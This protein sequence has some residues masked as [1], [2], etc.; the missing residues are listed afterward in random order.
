MNG[1][2]YGEFHSYN[3]WGLLL[4]SHSISAPVPRRRK[5][6]ILGRHGDL[7][8]S[9]TLTGKILYENRTITANF[10]LISPRA[11][12]EAL[13]TEIQ[14][15]IHAKDLDI[16]LDDDPGYYYTG[17]VELSKWEPGHTTASITITADIYPYKREI[18]GGGVTL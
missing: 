3:T 4:E 16:I 18:E 17:F 14:E 2:Q 5:A 1:I 6:K 13:R 7:D 12:W 8:I 10:V 11:T 9:K 15:A